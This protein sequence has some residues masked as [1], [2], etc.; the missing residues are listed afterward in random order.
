VSCGA[1]QLFRLNGINK[2]ALEKL[3]D[4]NYLNWG[5]RPK[6]RVREDFEK[7]RDDEYDD[8]IYAGE[9]VIFSDND[10]Y[11]NG[12]KLATLIRV[13]KLGDVVSLSGVN[14][15]T[16]SKITTYLWRYNGAKLKTLPRKKTTTKER[17]V[18][19]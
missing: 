2:A 16:R 17:I 10:S 9:T 3:L 4:S 15:N 11:G 19:E 7:P 18:L 8:K 12:R 1:N 13:H 6:T 5:N 14:P